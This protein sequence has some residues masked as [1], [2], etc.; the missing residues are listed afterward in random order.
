VNGIAQGYVAIGMSEAE[1]VDTPDLEVRR[2]HSV[3]WKERRSAA[4]RG[5]R[6]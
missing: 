4:T 5:Q 6:N 3:F 1:D 2:L